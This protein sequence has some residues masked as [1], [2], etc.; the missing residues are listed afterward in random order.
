MSRSRRFLIPLLLLVFLVLTL[1]AQA[2]EPSKE[3][4]KT[5]PLAEGGRVEVK[6][7]KGSV[8][9]TAEERPD[10]LV[11]A[12]VTADAVCGD[13]RAQAEWVERTQVRIDT[14]A[15]T[16]RIESDYEDLSSFRFWFFGGC[17]AR[18][19]VDYRIRMPRKADLE[20]KDYKSRIDVAGLSG[21][22]L[23]DSYKGSMR[24]RDIDGS[25]RLNTYKGDASVRFSA[26]RSDSRLK[27]YKGLVEVSLP[28]TAA[29]DLDTDTGRRGDFRTDFEAPA[30]SA[31]RMRTALNGGGPK[32]ALTTYKGELKL[33]AR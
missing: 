13:S 8:D 1:A 16:V 20:V 22:V 30:R 26:L 7:Y 9:V 27:T 19:L 3:V 28:K 31:G 23:V 24:L 4:R 29:F 14:H 15:R 5:I 18:P 12:R 25:V 6:T 10:V 21:E 2:A 17:T 32:L 33:S 11:E